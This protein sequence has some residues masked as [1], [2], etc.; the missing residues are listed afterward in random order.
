MTASGLEYFVDV[1]VEVS[2]Q[3]REGEIVRVFQ[4]IKSNSPAFEVGMEFTG[5]IG[6]KDFL[7]HLAQESGSQLP[8]EKAISSSIPD[9][10]ED[11]PTW[12]TEDPFPSLTIHDLLDKAKEN[13]FKQTDIVNA[14]R[15]YHNQS[16]IYRLTAEQIRDL[17]QRM[18]ARISKTKNT[19][20]EETNPTAE[21][22]QNAG[23]QRNTKEKSVPK[24]KK[25]V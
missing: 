22:T 13:G 11:K 5:N 9:V 16:N 4:I 15:I 25:S 1:M 2:L 12:I 14:A 7:N 24:E 17:D 8:V 6:F 18:S 20:T 23:L 21:P 10:L 3:E 19:K